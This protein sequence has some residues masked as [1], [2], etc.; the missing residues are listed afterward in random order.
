MFINGEDTPRDTNRITLNK[1]VKD[2]FGL[3]VANVHVDEHANDA[4]MRAHC[5]KQ[6]AMM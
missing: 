3:P 6:A 1:D 4:A 5:Q 2:R